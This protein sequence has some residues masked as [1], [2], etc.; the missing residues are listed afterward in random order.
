MSR[1]GVWLLVIASVALAV[2]ASTAGKALAGQAATGELLF[3]P[4]TSCH[5]VQLGADGKPTKKLPNDFRGHQIKLVGHDNLGRGDRACLQCHDDPA[6]DPGMLKVIDGDLIPITGDVSAVCYRCHANK[7]KDWK[8]GI[9]GKRQ[10]K[11]TAAGCHNPHTPS[12]IYAE[13][14]MPFQG[15]GFQVRAVSQRIPFTPLASPPVDPAVET[16][17]WLVLAASLGAIVVAGIV[18]TLTL[19]RLKR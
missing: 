7:Y 18:G 16:P 8:A 14:L 6:K 4:C 12:W 11:C 5:P 10:P 3:Y 19:G 13:P 2:L 17:L 15:T 1:A 9:H